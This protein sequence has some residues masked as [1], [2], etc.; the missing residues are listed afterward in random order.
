MIDTGQKFLSAPSALT[1]VTLRLMSQTLN[2]NVKVFV[3]VFKT[4]LFPNLITDFI[5]LWCDDTYLSKIL[6][7]TIPTTQG[8]VKV[9]F[10]DLEFSC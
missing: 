4:S 7:S 6:R 2:L 8:H 5:H 9:K 3:K 10:T 1:T